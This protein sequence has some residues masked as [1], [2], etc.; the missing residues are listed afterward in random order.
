MLN[1]YR[2]R[3][4]GFSVNMDRIFY[5]HLTRPGHFTLEE[6]PIKTHYKHELIMNEFVPIAE[7]F[8]LSEESSHDK[9]LMFKDLIQLISSTM[10]VSKEDLKPVIAYILSKSA[11][12]KTF[13]SNFM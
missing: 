1:R 8:G 13:Y 6:L 9:L 11:T 3:G 2:F 10:G 4:E 12:A 7:N 5:E